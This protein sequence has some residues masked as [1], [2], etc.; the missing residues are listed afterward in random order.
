MEYKRSP[1]GELNRLASM[2]KGSKHWNWKGKP[3]LLTLHK[4]LH[5]RYGKA[6]ERQCVKCPK[7]A[8][9]WANITGNYTDKIEDYAAMCRSCHEKMDY[10]EERR[11]RTRQIML[12]RHKKNIKF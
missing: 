9:D 12:E 6:K 3:N 1:Q 7:Q 11:E 4:R 5:R 2:P 10:T 8:L